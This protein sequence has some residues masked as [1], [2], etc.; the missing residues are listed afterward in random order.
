VAIALVVIVV[1]LIVVCGYFAM[2]YNKLV[3][4]QNQVETA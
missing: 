4:L 2:T 3:R 1:L